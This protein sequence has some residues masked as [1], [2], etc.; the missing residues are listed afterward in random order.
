MSRVQ[1]AVGHDTVLLN[2]AVD[3]LVMRPDGIYVDGTYGRGGHARAVL[4]RLSPQGRLVAFD[5]DPDAI[6]EAAGI[7]EG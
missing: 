2:E 1:A 5:K 7:V 4:A 3:A 6:N